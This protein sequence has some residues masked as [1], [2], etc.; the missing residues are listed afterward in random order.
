MQY[1]LKK[2]LHLKLIALLNKNEFFIQLL[3]IFKKSEITLKNAE[4]FHFLYFFK[5][6]NPLFIKVSANFGETVNSVSFFIDSVFPVATIV[7]KP[8]R[9][10][11]LTGSATLTKVFV[12][13]DFAIC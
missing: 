4:S 9:L 2:I 1:F 11:I 3:D 10:V 6:A 12:F 8:V 13:I 7:T 5:V